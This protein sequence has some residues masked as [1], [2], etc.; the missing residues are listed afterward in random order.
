MERVPIDGGKET[1]QALLDLG[2]RQAPYITQKSTVDRGHVLHKPD[3]G[4]II[5]QEE[6]PRRDCV[7]D[8]YDDS[9]LDNVRYVIH[10][11]ARIGVNNARSCCGLI[12]DY[13]FIFAIT[14]YGKFL[15][16][17]KSGR[18]GF[19]WLIYNTYVD[20]RN[21]DW[22]MNKTPYPAAIDFTKWESV[23]GDNI[24]TPS[25]MLKEYLEE[26]EKIYRCAREAMERIEA[27]AREPHGWGGDGPFQGTVENFLSYLF[28]LF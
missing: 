22:P 1:I 27:A 18:E 15:N 14:D 21:D 5:I 20:A 26:Q 11:I 25:P 17:V 13:D 28:R 2:Y 12:N 6:K 23:I 9:I 16:L 24:L 8:E 7:H 4:I 19:D 3:H 10:C